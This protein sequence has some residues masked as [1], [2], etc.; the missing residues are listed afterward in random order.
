VKWQLP[1]SSVVHESI[2]CRH[3]RLAPTAHMPLR[4]EPLA[5]CADF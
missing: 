3:F 1:G 2:S 5:A 4:A